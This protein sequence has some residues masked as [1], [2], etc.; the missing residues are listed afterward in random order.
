MP[1]S[2][3]PCTT[4]SMPLNHIAESSTGSGSGAN[5]SQAN[6]NKAMMVSHQFF[7]K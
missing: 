5:V 4:L 2:I 6:V 1:H 3:K 7:T